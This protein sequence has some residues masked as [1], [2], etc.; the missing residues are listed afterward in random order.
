MC[1]CFSSSS[2]SSPLSL[3]RCSPCLTDALSACS[4][5]GPPGRLDFLLPFLTARITLASHSRT[6]KNGPIAASPVSRRTPLRLKQMTSSS[7]FTI[8][9]CGW[10]CDADAEEEVEEAAPDG[11]VE[12]TPDDAPPAEEREDEEGGMTNAQRWRTNEKRRKGRHKYSEWSLL[13]FILPWSAYRLDSCR[14]TKERR[15]GRSE[16][17]ESDSHSTTPTRTHPHSPS[18]LVARRVML[19]LC[20]VAR[21]VVCAHGRA[22]RQ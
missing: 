13:A 17:V 14:Q 8:R 7:S 9:M 5:V 19:P 6:T 2:S 16:D 18:I 1:I 10:L 21:G 11:A 4:V 22:G 15:L 3:V 12:P 20:R